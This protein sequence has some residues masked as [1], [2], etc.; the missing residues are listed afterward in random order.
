VQKALASLCQWSLKVSS[1]VT[2]K[3]YAQE[4][5]KHADPVLWN[6]FAV[7]RFC[8]LNFLV[9]RFKKRTIERFFSRLLAPD[10][11]Q[12]A[13]EAQRRAHGVQKV[14]RANPSKPQGVHVK[15]EEQKLQCKVKRRAQRGRRSQRRAMAIARTVVGYGNGNFP[16]AARGQ[17]AGPLKPLRTMLAKQVKV[18]LM[19]EYRTSKVHAACKQELKVKYMKGWRWRKTPDPAS[20]DTV[21]KR[22]WE[23]SLRIVETRVRLGKEEQLVERLRDPWSLRWCPTCRKSVVR[24][25][26]SAELMLHLLRERLQGHVRPGYLSRGKKV[27]AKNTNMGDSSGT[28]SHAGHT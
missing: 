2:L 4:R 23:A 11:S 15:S 10:V 8:D 17:A 25:E 19:D 3:A 27:E 18:C 5:L 16:V 6:F 28:V 9:F 26:N 12:K 1:S 21:R 14:E 20:L 22:A 24:D 13:Y 7:S